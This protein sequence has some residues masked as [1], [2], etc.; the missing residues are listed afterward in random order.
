MATGNRVSLGM[1]RAARTDQR[2][3]GPEG[4]S[5]LSQKGGISWNCNYFKLL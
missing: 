1:M 5:V 4:Q 2:A 3:G